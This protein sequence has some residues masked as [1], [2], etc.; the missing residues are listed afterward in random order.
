MFP[1]SIARSSGVVG[2]ERERSSVALHAP[3]SCPNN[4]HMMTFS[5]NTLLGLKKRLPFF[6]AIPWQH[7]QAFFTP[8]RFPREGVRRCVKVKLSSKGLGGTRGGWGGFAT[9]LSQPTTRGGGKKKPAATNEHLRSL[10]GVLY[11]VVL[12]LYSSLVGNLLFPV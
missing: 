1:E 2:G 11:Q 10:Q 8:A 5:L 12:Y 6:C 9:R 7:R 4:K 3:S